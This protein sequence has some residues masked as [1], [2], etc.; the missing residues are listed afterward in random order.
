MT[1]SGRFEEAIGF[2][3]R[4]DAEGYLVASNSLGA[5][6]RR[7]RGAPRDTAKSVK[8][9]LSAAVGGLPAARLALADLLRDGDG[10]PKS[11]ELSLYWMQL[12]ADAGYDPAIDALANLYRSGI[13]VASDPLKAIE[14]YEKAAALENSNAMSNCRRY[15]HQGRRRS[16]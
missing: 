13:G 11:A 5:L 4:A 1:L 8:Y 10:V 2:Y 14:L 6:Y 7:G 15:V 16:N 12:A 9:I 3:L